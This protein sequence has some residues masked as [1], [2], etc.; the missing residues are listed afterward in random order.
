[1]QLGAGALDQGFVTVLDEF[2]KQAVLAVE[3]GI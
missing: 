2:L 3:M 1:M